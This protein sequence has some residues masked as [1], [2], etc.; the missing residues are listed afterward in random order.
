MTI[1]YRAMT[2]PSK[3]VLALQQRSSF[4]VTQ[5]HT[6]CLVKSNMST[7]PE[8]QVPSKLTFVH[9]VKSHWFVSHK[10]APSAIFFMTAASTLQ[11]YTSSFNLS[12]HY[13]LLKWHCATLAFLSGFSSQSSRE[14]VKFLCAM[15][16]WILHFPGSCLSGANDRVKWEGTVN[17]DPRG[18]RFVI[19]ALGHFYYGSKCCLKVNFPSS[20]LMYRSKL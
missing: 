9:S 12:I 15:L 20:D 19:H 10:I 7:V 13:Q 8:V 17:S 16:T 14:V 5:V 4:P 11:F 2:Y 18:L 6:C 1:Q 3:H